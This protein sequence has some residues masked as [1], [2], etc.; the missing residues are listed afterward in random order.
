M[1]LFSLLYSIVATVLSGVALVTVLV[2]GLP[3]WEPIVLALGLGA[4]LAV[5]VS[6]IAAR[7]LSR[8]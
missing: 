2:A 3:G 4:F 1:R 8:L 5:P 7:H 6:W